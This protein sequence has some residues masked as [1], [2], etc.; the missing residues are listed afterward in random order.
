MRLLVENF[1]AAFI[2]ETQCDTSTKHAVWVF[3]LLTPNNNCEVV[4]KSVGQCIPAQ[5]IER[6]AP[7]LLF[8]LAGRL[9]LSQSVVTS[10]LKA[11]RT[12]KLTKADN[13]R[14]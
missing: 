7:P 10:R 11:G 4:E 1:C 6:S 12:S 3:G 14:F 2:Q 13:L 8:Y 5:R 9:L